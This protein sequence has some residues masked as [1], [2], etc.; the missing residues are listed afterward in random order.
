MKDVRD[1]EAIQD[2][3]ENMCEGS[4][5]STNPRRQSVS[6]TGVLGKFKCDHGD[7]HEEDSDN[8]GQFW[9]LDRGRLMPQARLLNH[10][11]PLV[12]VCLSVKN[13]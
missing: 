11:A 4:E 9:N 6:F 5:G 2:G 3:G 10:G 7:G 1:K 8:M 13:S 12:M